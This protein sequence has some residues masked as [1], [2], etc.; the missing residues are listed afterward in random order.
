MRTR[1]VRAE[2]SGPEA[3]GRSS[4]PASHLRVTATRKPPQNGVRHLPF[5]E[6]QRRAG[7]SAIS[8]LITGRRVQRQS[9]SGGARHPLVTT[10][11][12][13]PA[14]LVPAVVRTLTDDD[15][16]VRLQQAEEAL[17]RHRV[18]PADPAHPYWTVSEE[19]SRAGTELARRAALAAGRTF[20]EEDVVAARQTF[21]D[22]AAKPKGGGRQECIVILNS[23]LKDVWKDPSQRHTNETIEKA[24]A[25][26][27][28]GGRAGAAQEI[29]FVRRNGKLTRGGARPEGLQSSLWQAAVAMT[30]GDPGWSMFGLSLMDGFHALTLTVD[31]ND[32]SAPKLFLS[33][34][35]PGW[36]DGWKEY[37]AADLDAHVLHL[38]Q[39]WW[40]GMAEGRKHTTVVRLWRLRKKAS[41]RGD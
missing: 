30:A 16:R 5:T 4:E 9:D 39:G 21:Q 37:A 3:D 40:D 17:A 20:T 28:V 6:L 31:N 24:M 26:F 27:Q 15:L 14:L 10:P 23:V 36:T 29:W 33:D 7:N 2:L 1:R 34:Q 11:V 8:G 25:L 18:C 13:D 12:F 22:N 38:V 19:A 32:P 35:V 41:G